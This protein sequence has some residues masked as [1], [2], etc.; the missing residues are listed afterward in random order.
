M[1]EIERKYLLSGFPEHARQGRL[2]RMRQGYVPGTHIHERLREERDGDVVRHVRT[3]KLGRGVSRIE[4]EEEVEPA[5]FDALY[6]LTVGRRVEKDRYV[7]EDGDATWEIDRFTDRALVLAEIELPAIDTPV[8]FPA[9]LA[10]HVVREVTDEPAY[11]NL[12]LAR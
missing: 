1:V 9:W 12:N 8:V 7:V 4:V 3:V 6:A 10:A 2:L 11:L 5:L